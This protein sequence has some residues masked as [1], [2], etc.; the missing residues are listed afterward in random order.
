MPKHETKLDSPVFIAVSILLGLGV[1]IVYSASSFKAQEL[2]G[3]SHF[4]LKNHLYKVIVGILLML[5]LARVNYRFWLNIS[6]VLLVGCFI[7]LLYLLFSPTVTE[8]R[9]SRRWISFAGFAVQPSDFARLALILFLSLSL[10]A[11]DFVREKTLKSFGFH[12]GVIAGIALP[13]LLQ[14]DAGSA[15]LLTLIALTILFVAGEKLRYLLMVAV[16]ALPPLSIMLLAE[17]YQKSRLQHFITSIT[18]GEV[19]WQAKQSLIALG[20]GHIVGLGLG[21]S[22]QKLHFLPDPFTD[23]IFAIVGEELGLLGTASILLLFWILIGRGFYIARQAPDFQG[24]I[25]AIGITISLAVYATTNIG[26]VLNVLPTT[27]IPLPFLSY[28]GSALLVNLTMVGI[29][30]NIASQGYSSSRVKPVGSYAN[31]RKTSSWN[32]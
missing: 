13:I 17:G 26:V 29:L 30:L 25:L 7:T 21:G 31:R 9:G 15:L 3:D 10:G 23:F 12:L 27:G 24:K 5:V 19:G 8:I 2:M 16:L 18:G 4:F 1:V 14:P 11:T 28:G 20:N 6:P 32:G 22:L